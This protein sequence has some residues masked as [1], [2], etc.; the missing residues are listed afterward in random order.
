[1]EWV[2]IFPSSQAAR[3]R[4]QENKPQLLILHG[5]RICLVLRNTK[6]YALEDTCSHSGESLSRGAVNYLGEIVCPWHAYCFSL[7]SGRES[8]ERS[9]DL[10][11][12]PIQEDESG[13]YIRV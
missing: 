11:C 10:I 1:M 8:G 4:L 7:H 6:F 9:R 2:K 13:F 5:K 12:Y 3:E